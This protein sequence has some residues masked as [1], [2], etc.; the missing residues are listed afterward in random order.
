[1]LSERGHQDAL[2]L[3][4]R[5]KTKLSKA[6][7]ETISDLYTGIL[8]HI[9]MD[10][11]INYREHLRLEVQN[12]YVSKEIGNPDSSWAEAIRESIFVHYRKELEVG[13]IADLTKKVN[14]LEQML[15][16]RSRP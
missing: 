4:E 14:H 11:W 3:I 12:K 8:P 1:E 9:E 13:I 5:F 2:H 7:Q 15:L 16:D 10:A 6:A